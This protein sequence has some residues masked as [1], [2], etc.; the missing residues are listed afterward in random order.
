MLIKRRK[1]WDLPDS[2][3]TDERVFRERRRL[4]QAVGVGTMLAAGG[5]P[6]AALAAKGEADPTAGLYPVKR[7]PE[8]KVARPLT[9]DELTSA[10]R[11]VGKECVR[12]C[13]SRGSP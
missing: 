13:R 8:Y 6:L 9:P 4:M 1:P 3:V 10:E 2:A 5:M 7:N 11:R 12:T